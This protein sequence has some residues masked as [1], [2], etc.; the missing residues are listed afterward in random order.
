ML[1]GTPASGLRRLASLLTPFTARP[2]TTLMRKGETADSFVLLT[3]GAA[4]VVNGDGDGHEVAVVAEGS[5]VGEI[6]LLRGRPHASTVTAVTPVSGLMGGRAGVAEIVVTRA[7]RRFA[8]GLVPV[9]VTLSDGT[10]L[11]LRPVLPADQWRL[12]E[13]AELVSAGTGGSSAC[14]GSHRLLPGT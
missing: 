11:R 1:A 14:P 4:H 8:A 2:G 3:D 6:A 5:I 9:P 10:A 12:R 13:A 7:R